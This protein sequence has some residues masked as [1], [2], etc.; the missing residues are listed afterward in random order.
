M[1][2]VSE[3]SIKNLEGNLSS[4]AGTHI[5]DDRWLDFLRKD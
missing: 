4:D 1:L 2:I 3:S 5:T